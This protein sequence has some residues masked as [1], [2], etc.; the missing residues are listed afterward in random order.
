MVVRQ[1]ASLAAIRIVLGLVGAF[2]LTRLLTTMLF[3]IGATDAVTFAAAPFGIMLVVLLATFVP[4][5]LA[6]RISP[7]VALRY[8]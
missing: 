8:E 2:A 5:L 1:A 3:V 7:A 4:A 6:T